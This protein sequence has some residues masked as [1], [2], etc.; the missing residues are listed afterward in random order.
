MSSAVVQM[1][2]EDGPSRLIREKCREIIERLATYKSIGSKD[3]AARV[4]ATLDRKHASPALMYFA[5]V[6]GIAQIARDELRGRHGFPDVDDPQIDAFADRLNDRYPI[7]R[8][9]QWE[10][11]KYVLR[12]ECSRQEIRDQIYPKLARAIR[13]YTLHLDHLKRWNEARP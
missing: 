10:D 9:S 7:R 13:S 2:R 3:V 12:E 11:E 5:A 6:E 1:P 8:P 4:A